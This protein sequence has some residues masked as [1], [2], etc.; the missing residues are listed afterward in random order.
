MLVQLSV[1]LIL[2]NVVSY[3]QSEQCSAENEL[4]SSC[5]LKE[6]KQLQKTGEYMV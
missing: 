5:L 1:I 3:A 2:L 4:K 6:I